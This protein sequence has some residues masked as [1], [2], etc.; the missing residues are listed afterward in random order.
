MNYHVRDVRPGET[1][2]LLDLAR[3]GVRRVETARSVQAEREKCDDTGVGAQEAKLARLRPRDLPDDP[4]H[5][6]LTTL[7]NLGGRPALRQRLEVR[8]DAL[9]LR[10]CGANGRLEA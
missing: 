6:L 9:D 10:H 1:D 5:D 4:A 7:P 2:L 8:L 3:P